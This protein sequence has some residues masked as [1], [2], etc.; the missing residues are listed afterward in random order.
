MYC[1]TKAC[2][3]VLNHATEKFINPKI[4]NINLVKGMEVTYIELKNRVNKIN[5]I[6][7][8]I[9]MSLHEA[10]AA[11]EKLWKTVQDYDHDF[12]VR[13]TIADSIKHIDYDVK[14]LI[15][16]IVI[17]T[18]QDHCDQ[19][20]EKYVAPSSDLRDLCVVN[21]GSEKYLISTDY[22]RVDIVK[23]KT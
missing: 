19:D 4:L 5:N 17:N 20:V 16:N 15:D 18:L 10:I 14:D 9:N 3:T 2:N 7:N 23:L 21:I 22:K 12:K 6:I 8:D 11:L 13:T 1:F